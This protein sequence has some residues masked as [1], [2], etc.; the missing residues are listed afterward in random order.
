MLPKKII[1]YNQDDCVKMSRERTCGGGQPYCTS[2]DE[3]EA[4]ARSCSEDDD[5]TNKWCKKA[6]ASGETICHWKRLS[7]LAK[8]HDKIVFFSLFVREGMTLLL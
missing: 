3:R 5:V 6:A 8:Q 7:S 1:F 2:R 4:H